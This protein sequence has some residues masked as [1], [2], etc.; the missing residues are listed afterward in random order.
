MFWVHASTVAR[1]G[2]AYRDI[3]RKLALPGCNDHQV[4]TLGLV[5]EWL[6]DRGHGSWLMVLDNA[7]DTETLFSAGTYTLIHESERPAALFSYI[8]KSPKGSVIITTRDARVGERL[9]DREKPISVRPLAV[10]EAERLLRF[11]LTQ[12]RE[13]GEADIAKLLDTLECLPLAITQAAAFM[14]G[15]SCR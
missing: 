6:S 4:N 10:Q 9:A 7:D 11:K 15:V 1:S 3:A 12:D 14:S 5:A 8:P 13:W 2:Q